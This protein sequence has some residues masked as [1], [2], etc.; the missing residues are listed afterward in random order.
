MSNMVD[1]EVI[2][3]FR[4]QIGWEDE[5][6]LIEHGDRTLLWHPME[7]HIP[8]RWDEL[9]LQEAIALRDGLG[10][11]V[12]LLVWGSPDKA[13]AVEIYLTCAKA[14]INVYFL[15]AT[16]RVAQSRFITSAGEGVD[17]N[18]TLINLAHNEMKGEPIYEW[19]A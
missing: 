3:R 18:R 1:L 15:D 19:D 17:W 13:S 4:A 7:T 9:D 14:G 6:R 8:A 16:A 5:T 2:D 10:H 12:A 11:D